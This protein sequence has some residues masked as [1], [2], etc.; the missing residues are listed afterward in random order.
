MFHCE[1]T[2]AGEEFSL[3][4]KELTREISFIKWLYS[5]V[6][7]YDSKASSEKYTEDDFW[8]AIL[9]TPLQSAKPL[10][11]VHRVTS[12][13]RAEISFTTTSPQMAGVM[14]F[15]IVQ[16]V[17][18]LVPS[19]MHTPPKRTLE[20][21]IQIRRDESKP[22]EQFRVHIRARYVDDVWQ[23][24]SFGVESESTG[25]RA[26]AEWD[27]P[28]GPPAVQRIATPAESADEN[29]P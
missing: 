16:A 20:G 8:A 14:N 6:A 18:I 2:L 4:E 27:H 19:G 25:R 15:P 5:E 10:Y 28:E 21:V 7:G 9:K 12:D 17:T 13:E 11:L 3:T 24:E 26:R 29:R 23:L 1:R 22:F